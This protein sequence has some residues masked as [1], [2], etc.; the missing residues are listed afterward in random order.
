LKPP[1]NS[2]PPPGQ[3]VLKGGDELFN[4]KSV[5]EFFEYLHQS[6]HPNRKKK[7]AL[8]LGC[9]KH[10]PFS[11][12][13]MH[14]KICGMLRKHRLGVIVQQYILSEP[15]TICPRELET[16]F[17]AA[18]YDFPPE[19]LS[20]K[21]RRIFIERLRMFLLK[22][23]RFHDY[24]IVFAPNHHKQIFKEA[25]QELIVANFVPYNVYYLP[26]L[27]NA[28]NNVKNGGNSDV[29]RN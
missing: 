4:H 9:S 24:H 11:V 5:K 8:Y 26:K 17:P 10:K 29:S 7:I 18:H 12:S 2:S 14:K 16:H 15:L 13:F 22:T 6:W 3:I 21:G 20:E 1:Q 19:R 23:Q 25:S 27:L 28:L